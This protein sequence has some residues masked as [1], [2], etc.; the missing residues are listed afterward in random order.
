MTSRSLRWMTELRAFARSVGLAGSLARARARFNRISGN[1]G[2]EAKFELALMQAIRLGDVV[3]D[4]GANVGLYT[5]QFCRAVGERGRV[6]AFEPTPACFDKLTRTVDGLTNAQLFPLALGAVPGT[7]AMSIAQDPLSATHS[8]AVV[9]GPERVLVEVARGDDLVAS[10]IASR[11]NVV[12]IDVEG[13]ERE[14]I[15]G[16]RQSI[17]DKSCR[18]IFCEVHFGLLD[19]RGQRQAPVQIVELIKNCG[20]RTR[21]I[22]ASHLAAVRPC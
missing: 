12:K 13:F 4:V 2:Y 8:L 9:A 19:K 3:W 14:V 21:W 5:T 22:D 16:L 20:F 11:P 10:G 6:L 17:A 15:I 1:G 7:F 18:A